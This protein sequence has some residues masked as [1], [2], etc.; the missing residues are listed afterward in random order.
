MRV[1]D[2]RN[3]LQQGTGLQG[4]HRSRKR[5]RR[6]LGTVGLLAG[7]GGAILL[8]AVGLSLFWDG[9]KGRPEE[10]SPLS[11]EP[12]HTGTDHGDAGILAG[13][14]DSSEIMI[15]ADLALSESQARGDYEAY[16]AYQARFEGIA[17]QSQIQEAGFSVIQE[18][19]FPLE[20]ACFGPVTVIPAL[21]EEHRRLGLFFAGPEGE[22]C[23]RT[24]Q[25]E[26]NIRRKGCLDQ[27]NE[28]IA[29]VSFQDVD[30]DGLTDILL[31]TLCSNERAGHSGEGVAA[32]EAGA[33]AE[34]GAE[35]EAGAGAGT[36]A[37]TG[38]GTGAGR[39][40][41]GG[42]YKIGDVLFQGE[43]GFYRDWRLSDKLNR[44]SMNK[45]VRFVLSFAKEGRST[46]FLYSAAT[47]EELEAGGLVIDEARRSWQEFEKL[48]RLEVIPGV[49]RMAEYNI[50]MVY[51]V[52]ER[53]DIVWSFQPMGDHENLYELLGVRCRD[54]DGDGLKDLAVLA[55]YGYETDEGEMVTEKDY[56]IYCQRT[57]GFLTDE[58]MKDW[59]PC[60]EETD[61]EELEAR[62]GLFWGWSG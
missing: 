18:Q 27:C 50:L 12:V 43:D 28:G 51:L 4:D 47:L 26:T 1:G 29:A 10:S 46:E 45:S 13:E 60:Q 19:V 44:F 8:L 61:M 34:A 14:I 6:P 52:D 49:Y 38:A 20:T 59:Y 57:G 32:V 42:R 11:A 21:D 24:E 17:H 36:R 25:L 48:G 54:F 16:K 55:R 3:G 7:L 33:G 31:I 39:G 53:G 62:A 23:Y 15:G 56:Q 40:S 37:E 22:I 30:E 41:G 58:E 2:E 9:G 5:K 35:A